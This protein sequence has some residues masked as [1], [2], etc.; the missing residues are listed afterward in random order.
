M[1]TGPNLSTR[2]RCCRLTKLILPMKYSLLPSWIVTDGDISHGAVCSCAALC[3]FFSVNG[4]VYP[5]QNILAVLRGVSQSAISGQMNQ[6]RKAGAVID[7]APVGRKHCDAF[8][9]GNWYIVPLRSGDQPPPF[10]IIRT[11]I[12]APV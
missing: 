7:L 5:S 2:Y 10:E 3:C 8:K 12:L 11:D 6:L 4:I 9:C 1:D